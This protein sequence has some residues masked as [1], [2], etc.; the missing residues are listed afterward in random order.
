MIVIHLVR[1]KART[2][3]ERFFNKLANLPLFASIRPSLYYLPVTNALAY[4]SVTKKR[5]YS[6]VTI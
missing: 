6:N 5:P 2:K 1:P 4:L 3:L